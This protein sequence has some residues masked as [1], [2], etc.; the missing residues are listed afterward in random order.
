M[1][2]MRCEVGEVVMESTAQYWRPVR[3]A[4]WRQADHPLPRPLRAALDQLDT[5][6]QHIYEEAAIAA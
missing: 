3:E 4:R 5:A 6:I 1:P 2:T